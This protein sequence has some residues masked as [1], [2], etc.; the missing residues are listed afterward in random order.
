MSLTYS[1]ESVYSNS[2]LLSQVIQTSRHLKALWDVE[3]HKRRIKSIVQIIFEIIC[4]LYSDENLKQIVEK[5]KEKIRVISVVEKTSQDFS[6]DWVVNSFLVT[7]ATKKFLY[8]IE[9]FRN[10]STY[11]T[12]LQKNSEL[13]R[14][15]FA[16]NESK[17]S[18]VQESQVTSIERQT[19]FF[20]LFISTKESSFSFKNTEKK[21]TLES[22]LENQK[23]F[24]LSTSSK[25]S[26]NNQKIDEDTSSSQ[27]TSTVDRS[28][29]KTLTSD[30]LTE[31]ASERVQTRLYLIRV[32]SKKNFFQ[33]SHLTSLRDFF[34]TRFSFSS[35]KSIALTTISSKANKIFSDEYFEEASSAMIS[36]FNYQSLQN[37]VQRNYDFL[38]S[39][40]WRSQSKLIINQFAESALI[41]LSQN[42]STTIKSYSNSANFDSNREEASQHNIANFYSE[43]KS[44]LIVLS[45]TS[46][47]HTQEKNFFFSFSSLSL[48]S[49][50]HQFRTSFSSDF[51]T[52]FVRSVSS[53]R[54]STRFD[55][56][57]SRLEKSKVSHHFSSNIDNI[58]NCF[59][60][61]DSFIDIISAMSTLEENTQSQAF[62]L[63]QQNIQRIALSMFNL[64][65]QN[66]HD[67]TQ[68]KTTEATVDVVAIAKKSF[69]RAF[70][71]RFF[72]SQ[73]NSFYE[74]NDVIQIKRDLY[75]RD[76]Y[77]FVE[78]VK[79]AIMMFDVEVVRTNLSTCLKE[80]TQVWYTEELNDLKKKALRTLNES[81]DHW[82]NALLK[83]IQK[84]RRFSLELSNHREI[85]A[86]RREI[87]QRYFQLRVSDH[88][89]RKSS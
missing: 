77:L 59:S 80:S 68:T 74:S 81:A 38:I 15:S 20:N 22:R 39:I 14:S 47:S 66:V 79:D 73:L 25:K 87:K 83:K 30:R 13:L 6:F 34:I 46:K 70:D 57:S 85:H 27:I 72:D 56:N 65:A 88:A 19:S 11:K 17:N 61:S 4:H 71:V 10:S 21:I 64:F 82:C 1:K 44:S 62:T 78:R 42:L 29:S 28:F 51:F 9:N 3:L 40:L 84:I 49:L 50:F 36:Q 37:L 7:V 31:E 86:E 33:F 58:D 69:F 41:L 54:L 75:Y 55:S 43:K 48:D 2:F 60:K 67:Q 76:V 63:S 35:V 53:S 12:F 8:R 52:S 32:E 23:F 5:S 24:E 89:T 18:F 26:Q 16:L 45:T